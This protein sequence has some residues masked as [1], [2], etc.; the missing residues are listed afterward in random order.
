MRMT[1]SGNARIKQLLVMPT[2][3]S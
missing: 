2:E 1:E 3:H